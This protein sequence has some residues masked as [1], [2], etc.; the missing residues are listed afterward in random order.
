MQFDH[1]VYVFES[2]TI[3]DDSKKML[4]TRLSGIVTLA[5]VE[6]WITQFNDVVHKIPSETI[7]SMFSNI[8]GFKAIN[9]EAHKLFRDV[10]PR[11][12]VAH[13]MLPGYA[14]LF[15]EHPVEVNISQGKVVKACAHVHHDEGKIAR[16]HNELATHYEDYFTRPEDALEW[17]S[18]H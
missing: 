9:I 18:K 13:G 11:F 7:F 3:W 17:L 6:E 10:V 1:E 14:K 5:Q 15:P 2:Y 8:H 16:Y 4:T 12:L